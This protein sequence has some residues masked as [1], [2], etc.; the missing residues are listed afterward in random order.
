MRV[1]G[2]FMVNNAV[3]DGQAAAME[4]LERCFELVEELTVQAEEDNSE[5]EKD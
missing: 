3:P 2:K 5:D 4:L 1:D